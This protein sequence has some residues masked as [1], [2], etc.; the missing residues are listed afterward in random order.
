VKTEPSI[1]GAFLS[2]IIVTYNSAKDIGA[3]LASIPHELTGGRVEV[4]VV[5]NASEDTT[6]RDI[7]ASHP[8][9]TVIEAGGNLGFS[10]ANN[11]GFDRA[12][13]DHI[14]FLNPDTVINAAALEWCLA[15][16]AGEPRIGIIS[17]RLV[18]ADGSLDLACRRAIPTVW[19]GFT[20]ASG[21]AKIFPRVRFLAG[22]NLTW[23]PEDGTYPVGSVNGAFML[24][25]RRVLSRIGLFDERF[26]MYGEDLDLCLRCTQAGYQVVYDGRHSILHLKGQSSR[27]NSHALADCVFTSTRDFYLKHFNVGNSPITR[28]K[29][30]LLFWLWSRANRFRAKRAHHKEARPL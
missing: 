9:V 3:C 1:T 17:P 14:L 4:I 12:T 7:K 2:V 5:D 8:W 20:R 6:T 27:Q 18:L 13:G 25:S 29:Y 22:Y 24:T 23:L 15:R 11:V 26:F 21:L 30:T 16:I 28:A 19:D 10:K